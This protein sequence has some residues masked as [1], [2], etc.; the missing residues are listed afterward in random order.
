MSPREVEEL[1]ATEKAVEVVQRVMRR[2]QARAVLLAAEGRVQPRHRPRAPGPGSPFRSTDPLRPAT[3]PLP[4]MSGR[5]SGSG[6]GNWNRRDS[7]WAGNQWPSTNQN[8]WQS[9]EGWSSAQPWN[10]TE[11]HDGTYSGGFRGSRRVAYGHG[12]FP[13]AKKRG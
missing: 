6:S 3:S 4:V 5:G 8:W 13:A 9:W 1:V 12:S 10:P 11:G 2:F 7:W